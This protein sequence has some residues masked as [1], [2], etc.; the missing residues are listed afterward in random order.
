MPLVVHPSTQGHDSSKYYK[1]LCEGRSA[2][3]RGLSPQRAVSLG[4]SGSHCRRQCGSEGGHVVTVLC[5]HERRGWGKVQESLQ[6][7]TSLAVSVDHIPGS[8]QPLS[9]R[10]AEGECR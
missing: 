7:E 1:P 10:V 8:T 6:A 2:L 3:A 9:H 4:P 5:L